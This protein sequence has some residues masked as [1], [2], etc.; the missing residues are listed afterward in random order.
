M[1]ALGVVLVLV[2]D[3]AGANTAGVFSPDV[4]A[5]ERRVTW[6]G[7]YTA[8]EGDL[9]GVYTQR[10]HYDHAL[11]GRWRLRLVAAQRRLD[12]GTFD[13]RGTRVEALWQFR[14][15][16]TDGWDAAL[17]FDLEA[18]H[19]GP[20]LVRVGASGQ[21]A[22][23][24][25]WGVRANVLLTHEIGGRTT[26]GVRVET[27]AAVA[28]APNDAWRIAL[29]SYNNYNTTASPG[30]FDDQRH[31]LGPLAS[32]RF[33]GGWRLHGGFL[34]GLSSSADDLNWR[35]ALDRAF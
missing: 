27:R 24:A 15:H 1:A 4:N 16:E 17:R 23:G 3:R 32:W 12:G 5:G 31:Q 25:R 30:S 8:S 33:G 34:V 20:D 22:L 35:L 28:W 29:E 14:E 9:P 6:R 21:L 10:F 13:Y 18:G 26:S 7:A 2:A 19:D 11:D